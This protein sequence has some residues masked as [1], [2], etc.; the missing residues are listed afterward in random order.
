[1]WQRFTERA[2]KVILLGQEEAQRMGSSR[3]DTEHLLLG[4][5]REHEGVAAQVLDKLNVSINKVRHEIEHEVIPAPTE[6]PSAEPKLTPRAKRVLELAADEARRMKHNYIGTEHLLLALLREKDGVAARVLRKFGLTLERVRQEVMEYLGPETPQHPTRGRSNTPALDAYGRDITQLA[7]DGQLDPVIGRHAEIERVIQILCRRTKNN[8]VLVGEAGVGKTAIVEGLA[9]RIVLQDVPEPLRDKRLIALDLAAVVAG[10][11]Y[12]GEFEER[13]KR[14]MH[15]IRQSQ[16]KIIVFIDELHTIVG[17]GAAE[18]AIDASNMLKPALA[19]GEL[20]CIGATT[21][22]EYRKYIEKNN[23]LERR[24]MMV[25]VAE[26]TVEETIEILKGLRPRYEEF[27]RVRITDEALREAAELSHRYITARMLPDKAI[28]VIDEASSRVKLQIALPP[29]EI[30]DLRR[31]VE[32][33]KAEKERAINNDEYERAAELRDRQTELERQLERLQAKWQEG[34]TDEIPTVTAD[35]IAHVVSEWTGVPVKRLTEEETE[36]LLHMEEELHKR[37]IG[38]D[39]AIKVVSKAIR[40]GRAGL[41]DPRRPTGVFVFVGPSGVGKTELARALAE[42][43]FG[44]EGALIKLD[45]SEY[46]ERFTVSR[47]F[48]SPPGYVGYDEGGQLTEAV[49]RR[50]YSVVLFDEIEKA[51]P[52]VFNSLLQIMDEGRL[53]DAQGRLIDFKNT[54]IIMTSNLGTADVEPG[55]GF[56]RTGEMSDNEEA[57]FKAMKS[58]VEEAYKQTFRPEFRNRIDNVVV[59]HHLTREHVHQIVDIMI[60]RVNEELAH[61]DMHIEL[62]EAAKDLL[63]KK[64]YDRSFGARPLRREIQ[65]LI[66]DPLAEKILSGEFRAGDT[67]LVDVSDDGEAMEFRTSV[68]LAR[69]PALLN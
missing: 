52:E 68:G 59:F 25:L 10:T 41:K 11:K 48:G 43:L 61:K 34:Q 27:H 13:M 51:H 4:L 3:V 54:V 42:F 18:G 6:P 38:Q 47:L 66:E 55:V 28:D 37:V 7:A 17:A 26:P 35:D 8:P 31:E 24:F 32:E 46:S 57:A 69:E 1:M 60:R 63:C 50:P 5:V 64:G 19:R 67:I 22:D 12:R 33:I 14:I 9:S 40:R 36:R 21:L 15:E 62:T 58:R 16:G 45:M 29:R 49:R 56:R 65:R 23:A 30:R 39:E 53:T 44:D 2:R 20:R